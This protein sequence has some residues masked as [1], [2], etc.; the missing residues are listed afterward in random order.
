MTTSLQP[1]EIIR[2]IQ[3][4]EILG[5]LGAGGM[6][7]IYRA[8]D[9]ARGDE[10]AI[11]M[12][13]P[14]DHDAADSLLERLLNRE[15]T[16]LRQIDH[17]AVVRYRDFVARLDGVKLLVMDLVPGPTLRDH[18]R[19]SG[20]LSWN[21]WL[22]LRDQL[23]SGLAAVHARGIVHRDLSPDNVV[24]KDGRP[25]QPVLIDFGVARD[26]DAT[27]GTIIGD[28]RVGKYL[29]A[30]PEQL[31][32]PSA[33]ST[34][35]DL[36][37]FGLV[38]AFAARGTALPMG[39]TERQAIERR[40]T[41]P[42]LDGLDERIRGQ[43]AMLLRPAI[44]ERPESLAAFL[45]R[46][47]AAS[48]SPPSSAAPDVPA[49]RGRRGMVVAGILIAA[50]LAAGAAIFLPYIR[51]D[52]RQRDW[53]VLVD[54]RDIDKL[55]D[56]AARHSGTRE[57]DLALRRLAQLKAG[58]DEEA[59][60]LTTE[61]RQ[62]VQA[63]LHA[64]GYDVGTPNGVFTASTRIAISAWQSSKGLAATGFLS[65]ST[66][67]R[68]A[69]D[70]AERPRRPPLL[71]TGRAIANFAIFFD[72]ESA[73]LRPEAGAVIGEVLAR[74]RG[75]GGTPTK[76]TLTSH[77]DGSLPADQ[78]TALALRMVN[79]VKAALVADGV[80][81]GSIAVT[82]REAAGPLDESTRAYNRRVDIV[83]LQ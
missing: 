51:D 33:V 62:S 48:P 74:Y 30:S 13:I 61:Q 20:P 28:R 73:A 41:T 45:A 71:P 72:V 54:S 29:Y 44:E 56:F 21:A 70:A 64:L 2:G 40:R 83:L 50:A 78:G 25:D 58:Q 12:V 46:A 26:R 47:E 68:L 42:D 8:R 57:G 53:A 14:P 43:L 6:G 79:A 32:D 23:A 69:A 67:D 82:W 7:S 75:A 5:H 18:V 59:L 60:S 55:A 1:G 35:S 52:I 76:I 3:D 27:G 24:L 10:V 38:M 66:L 49:S 19:R 22:Q 31:L 9:T 11:K 4:Y 15:A 37:S 34:A 17:R 16:T 80:P 65:R 39:E 77:V 63:A 36:Y 81:A